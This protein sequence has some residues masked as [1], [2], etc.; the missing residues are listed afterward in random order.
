M[1]YVDASAEAIRASATDLPSITEHRA[2]LRSRVRLDRVAYAG[3]H[4]AISEFLIQRNREPGQ[5]WAARQKHAHNIPVYRRAADTFAR[6][7]YGIA[8]TRKYWVGDQP[9]SKSDLITALKSGQTIEQDERTQAIQQ[10]FK[11][12]LDALYFDALMLRAMPLAIRDGARAF[13]AVPRFDESGA[14]GVTIADFDIEHAFPI[15][16]PDNADEIVAAVETRH[17]NDKDHYRLWSASEWYWVDE[18]MRPTR[19]PA[20]QLDGDDN[21]LGIIPF[22][23]L[24]DESR[25]EGN[26]LSDVIG[27]QRAAINADSAL[28]LGTRLQAHAVPTIKGNAVGGTTQTGKSGE[29][30]VSVNPWNMMQIEKD[31]DFYFANPGI[32]LSVLKEIAESIERKGLEVAGLPEAIISGN[33]GQNVQPTTLMIQWY[34]ALQIRNAYVMEAGK[35]EDALT[36]LL[37]V[38]ASTYADDYGLPAFSVDPMGTGPDVLDWDITFPESPLPHDRDAAEQRSRDQV[39]AGFKLLEDHLAEFV[40]PNDTPE[41]IIGKAAAIRQ[42]KQ[43]ALGLGA[44]ALGA[45]PITLPVLAP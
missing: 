16:A 17:I 2:A 43:D 39:E 21:V 15:R 34:T 22:V 24:G 30:Q 38:I 27:Y 3:G 13:K 20:G 5:Q 10:W 37:G 25:A 28:N 11:D 40:Y 36:N 6:L 19:P 32:N 35:F 8:P 41:E 42:Q 44:P 14:V 33:A 26:P 12:T 23:W 31:G 7:V 45:G 4:K 1:L 29:K 18:N 9:R